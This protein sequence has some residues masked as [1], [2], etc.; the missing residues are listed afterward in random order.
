MEK[1]T[2]ERCNTTRKQN[3]KPTSIQ[4][5]CPVK[6]TT[7][8]FLAQLDEEYKNFIPIITFEELAEFGVRT[9]KTAILGDA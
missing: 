2:C 7:N 3:K 8:K 1:C 4:K 6:E 9:Q 5:Q